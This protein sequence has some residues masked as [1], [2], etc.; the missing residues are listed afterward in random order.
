MHISSLRA[1]DEAAALQQTAQGY[2]EKNW[3]NKKKKL[4]TFA[5]VH[6]FK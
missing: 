3:R 5:W 2:T 1:I 4:I 6:L